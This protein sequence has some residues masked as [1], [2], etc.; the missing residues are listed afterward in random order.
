MDYGILS[1]LNPIEFFYWGINPHTYTCM[2]LSP[3]P[4]SWT[5]LTEGWRQILHVALKKC[6]S[7]ARSQKKKLQMDPGINTPRELGCGSQG[8]S[9][10]KCCCGNKNQTQVCSMNFLP[11]TST[12][13]S[14]LLWWYLQKM[15]NFSNWWLWCFSCLDPQ[16]RSLPWRS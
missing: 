15:P 11:A 2:I 14:P 5:K 4:T 3:K 13:H 8:N 16:E 7:C 6:Q 12:G 10:H 1:L 9:R